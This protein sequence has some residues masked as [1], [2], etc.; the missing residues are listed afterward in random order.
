MCL[1]VCVCV[2]VYLCV[3]E[4]A[5]LLT[6]VYS[7]DGMLDHAVCVRKKRGGGEHARVTECNAAGAL[8]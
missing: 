1:G 7:E 6:R 5:H 3:S 4:T 2:C 8:G